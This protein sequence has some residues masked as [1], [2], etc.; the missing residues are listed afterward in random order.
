MVKDD[1]EVAVQL[2]VAVDDLE[3]NELVVTDVDRHAE[4]ERGVPLVHNLLVAPLQEVAQ[5]GLT[6]LPGGGSE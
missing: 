2:D 4:V 5:L 1:V 3:R 6:A